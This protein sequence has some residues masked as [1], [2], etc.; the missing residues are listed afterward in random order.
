MG[1]S[2]PGLLW[3]V[4]GAATAALALLGALLQALVLGLTAPKGRRRAYLGAAVSGPLVAT[5]I[6]IALA[7]SIDLFDGETKALLDDRWVLLP[8]PALAAW[9]AI[10][11][12]LIRR[13]PPRDAP[14][15][16]V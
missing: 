14:S 15:D 1:P 3:F 12:V 16:K 9:L 5:G 6:A 11:R 2:L 10:N 13:L 7:V 8:L 4:V